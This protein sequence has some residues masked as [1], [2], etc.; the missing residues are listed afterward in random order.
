MGQN[1]PGGDGS[2]LIAR[3]HY[4]NTAL[5]IKQLRGL[6]LN[7]T[8]QGRNSFLNRNTARVVEGHGEEGGRVETDTGQNKG[9]TE[10]I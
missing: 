2:V 5:A 8:N 9:R 4:V 3:F 10:K 1:S 7:E 6:E